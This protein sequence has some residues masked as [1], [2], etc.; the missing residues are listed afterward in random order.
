MKNILTLL[1]ILSFAACGQNPTKDNYEQQADTVK[2]KTKRT[3]TDLDTINAFEAAQRI[4]HD[5][6]VKGYVATVFYAKNSSGKPTF[7]NLEEAFP[8]NPIAVI[9]F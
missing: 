2:N 8:N 7:L 9:I 3:I 5:V 1:L 6:I 4:D